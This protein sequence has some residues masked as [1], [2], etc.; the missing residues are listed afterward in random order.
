MDE[1][2]RP[3]IILPQARRLIGLITVLVFSLIGVRGR[4]RGCPIR[5]KN[6]TRKLYTAVNDVANRVSVRAQAF[7]WDV[8]RASMIASFEKK[9]AKK[10][11]PVKARLPIIRQEDVRGSR[12]LRPPIFRMSCSSLRLWIIEPEHRNSMALKKAWVQICMNASCGWF[13]PMVTI[14]RPS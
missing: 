10:G 11:V 14:I 9:P 4:N 2:I 6:T 13:S 1:I 8:F 5:A 7:K 12:L 3:A